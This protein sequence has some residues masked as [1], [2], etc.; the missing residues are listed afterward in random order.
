MK[1]INKYIDILI[2]KLIERIV[3]VAFSFVGICFIFVFNMN[4]RISAIELDKYKNEVDH[5]AIMKET[6]KIDIK[7]DKILCYLGEKISCSSK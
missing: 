3:Y 1:K 7:T 6:Q 5:L 2:E 4:A